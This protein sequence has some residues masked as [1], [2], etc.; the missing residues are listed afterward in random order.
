MRPEQKGEATYEDLL[1]LPESLI[2]QIIAGE[3]MSWSSARSGCRKI[4]R[5]E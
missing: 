3:L 1:A 4:R 5:V 2:G